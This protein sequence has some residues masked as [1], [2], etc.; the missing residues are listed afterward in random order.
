M[1]APTG[2]WGCIGD[3]EEKFW[4]QEGALDPPGGSGARRSGLAMPGRIE[5]H[6]GKEGRAGRESRSSTFHHVK[7]KRM[8]L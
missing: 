1:A 8:C 2:N 5:A 6:A 3:C 4:G 7:L